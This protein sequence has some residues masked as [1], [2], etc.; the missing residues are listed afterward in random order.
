MLSVK[1]IVSIESDAHYLNISV[2]S[3]MIYRT[4]MTINNFLQLTEND[5]RFITVNRGIV[6]NA[7]YVENIEGTLC[8]MG[9]G[10]RFPIKVREKS[11]IEKR[12]REHMFN[13]LR[14]NQQ[15]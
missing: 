8:V 13:K 12:I 9:N 14:T 1:E 6:L 3:G 15:I 7:D 5:Q 11:D 10:T 2:V 4:R